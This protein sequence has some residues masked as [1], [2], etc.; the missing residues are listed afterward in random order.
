MKPI[1]QTILTIIIALM[2]T[3][4]FIGIYAIGQY[5]NDLAMD[6][7]IIFSSD[8]DMEFSAIDLR[9]LYTYYGYSFPGYHVPCSYYRDNAE[10]Y[11][12]QQNFTPVYIGNNTWSG[13]V[14]PVPTPS[15]LPYWGG[16]LV[17]VGILM[18]ILKSYLISSIH[19]KMDLPGDPEQYLVMYLASHNNPYTMSDISYQVNMPVQ[20]CQTYT[21]IDHNYTLSSYDS[22]RI[23]SNAQINDYSY[24]AIEI[25]DM[26][27]DGLAGFDIN[28]QLEIYGS[29]VLTWSLQ[30]SINTVL[31][32]SI[33]ANI[34]LIIYMTDSIDF[35][36]V[37][38]KDL[39]GR[40]KGRK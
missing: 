26:E 4:S 36:G 35:G 15:P 25:E 24:M 1:N 31:A 11:F 19:L 5:Y 13:A 40:K 2:M 16:S 17:Y 32:I 6:D 22:L 27:D 9:D 23:H 21:T 34:G 8:S 3:S 18:P 33:S 37:K 10:T 14:P 29:P 39:N 28:L 7:Q 38:R 30:D 20:W 12:I